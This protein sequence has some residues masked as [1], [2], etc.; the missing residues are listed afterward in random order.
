MRTGIESYT[1]SLETQSA[2]IIANE[3]V[4]Y[5]AVLEKIKKTGKKVTK[6]EADGVEKAV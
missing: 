3:G 2:D 6:G 4:E 5:E 1:V